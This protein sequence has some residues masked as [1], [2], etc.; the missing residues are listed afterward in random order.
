MKFALIFLVL[1]LA[2]VF[3]VFSEIRSGY[4]FESQIGSNWKLAIKASTIQQKSEYVDKFVLAV[5]ESNAAKGNDAIFLKTPDN[6]LSNN[7]RAV[8]SLQSRLQEI[9]TMD[10]S[11]FQY[12]QAIAQITAQEQ[13]E[14]TRL[15]GTIES[16]W[17]LQS[18]YWYVWGWI[19]VVLWIS[20][21]LAWVGS[22]MWMAIFLDVM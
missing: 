20:L 16:G 21:M 9:K 14:A 12:Q 6:D 17:Y 15:I 4:Q 7:V 5:E 1:T 19:E 13:G 22:F 10:V 3:M 18:G 2:T 8:K 11:S